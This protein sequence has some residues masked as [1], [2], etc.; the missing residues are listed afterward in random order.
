MEVASGLIGITSSSLSGLAAVWSVIQIGIQIKNAPE[1]ARVFVRLVKHVKE[2]LEH[3][4]ACR[5]EVI[6]LMS[7]YPV[8]YSAWIRN[9]ISAT[10]A[11]LNDFGQFVAERN[12]GA[13]LRDRIRYL[14]TKSPE[15]SHRERG[16]RIAHNRLLAAVQT[17]HLLLLPTYATPPAL[18]AQNIAAPARRASRQRPSISRS[19]HLASPS[20]EMLESEAVKH[21]NGDLD[22]ERE[23]IVEGDQAGEVLKHMRSLDRRFGL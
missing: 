23:A 1:N 11:E 21:E 20:S 22:R 8:H 17:M 19:P 4:L 16:L 2:D 7:S 15:L 5:E 13:D 3:A 6:G 10:I 9:A 14:L 18:A 12:E